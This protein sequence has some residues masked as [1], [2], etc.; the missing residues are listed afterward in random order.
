MNSH[1]TEKAFEFSVEWRGGGRETFGGLVAAAMLVL[2]R[3]FGLTLHA[4]STVG[5][6]LGPP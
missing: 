2:C 1:E 3:C 5:V 6:D 4:N